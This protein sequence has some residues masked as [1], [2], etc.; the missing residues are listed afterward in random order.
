M[1]GCVGKR[2][3]ERRD[4]ERESKQKVKLVNNYIYVHVHACMYCIQYVI[5]I[6]VFVYALCTHI[7]IVET[8]S[9]P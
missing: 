2:R 7:I 1:K 4:S 6:D 5:C 9:D 8:A 3:E